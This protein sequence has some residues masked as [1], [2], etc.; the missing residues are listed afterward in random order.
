VV[1]LVERGGEARTFHVDR[2]TKA[3]VTKIVTDNIDR[4][5]YLHTDESRLYGD[6][7]QLF[8]EHRTVKHSV[9]EYV[10]GTVH[11]NTIESVFS[12]FRRGM[13]G[14]Y[15]HCSEKHLHCYLA[16][17][18]FRCNARE[19]LGLNDA[20]RAERAL[21]GVVGKRLTYER[22]IEGPNW[23]GRR[24]ETAAEAKPRRKMTRPS[25]SSGL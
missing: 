11:T 19:A 6:A 1:A 17:F 15:Q 3:A 18:D 21:K 16:E 22:L 23:Y 14:V 13:V 8:A 24:A 9:G 10:R 20:A 4:E 25:N 7:D 5:T 12:V 2:A